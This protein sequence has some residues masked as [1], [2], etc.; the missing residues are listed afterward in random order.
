MP[1]DLTRRRLLQ[2]TGATVAAGYVTTQADS[3]DAVATA[4][5]V[6][7][8]PIP[9]G[10]AQADSFDVRVRTPH[11]TWQPVSTYSVD[12]KVINAQ[13]G[14]GEI[15]KSSLAYFDFAGTVEVMVTYREGRVR[16]AQIRPLSYGI[17]PRAQDDTLRF[18]LGSHRQSSGPGQAS[19]RF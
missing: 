1:A 6:V 9:T 19:R 10:I 2:A 18:T 11:G 4:P 8:Y 16:R 13:T 15:K 17:E 7:T 12:L 5:R 3:A 14:A